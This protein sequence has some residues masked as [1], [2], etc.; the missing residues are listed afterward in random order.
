M[1]ILSLFQMKLNDIDDSM[2]EKIKSQGF[3]CIQISPV[4]Q[5]KDES[6]NE[7]WMLYQP[8]NFSVGNKYGSKSD[9]KYLCERCHKKGINV[10]VD[11]VI[12]HMAG[13]NTYG[14]L[15]PNR[16][17][18]EHLRNRNSAW[19]RKENI[20]GNEWSDRYKVTHYC[21]GVPG[22]NPND[23]MVQELV[24]NFLNELIDLGVDGF[25][26]DAA[27]SIGLP[28]DDDI[29][30]RSNFFPIITY[31]LKRPV[32]VIY[33]EVLNYPEYM[34]NKYSKYMK[35]LTD[36]NTSDDDALVRFAETKDT[37]KDEQMGY[38]RNTSASDISNRYFDVCKNYTN[39]LYYRRDNW[40]SGEWESNKVKDANRQRKR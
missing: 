25:R 36:V 19:R 33:G 32:Y 4:Q 26:F 2:I 15:D 28:N 14:S 3:D 1:R 10:I 18:D 30:N 34:I 40:E 37:F 7:W 38:T 6:S 35:V 9:L 20:K 22:L 39:S 5:T 29:N 24:I 17:I 21:M 27:K 23:E 13:E 12:A 16:Q 31:C 11:V 8:I